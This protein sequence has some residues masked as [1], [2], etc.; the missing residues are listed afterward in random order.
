MFWSL[1]DCHFS[2]CSL[3][4]LGLASQM[5]R[6]R[7]YARQVLVYLN[8]LNLSIITF[9]RTFHK[10]IVCILSVSNF[11]LMEGRC[12]SVRSLTC[13][14]GI[15]L[16]APP[17]SWSKFYFCHCNVVI[18]VFSLKYVCLKFNFATLISPIIT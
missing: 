8:T 7:Q 18:Y 3:S 11:D 5:S 17:K 16:D 4:S 10:N 1:V 13:F 15:W 9:Y 6:L 2:I 14:L 12:G